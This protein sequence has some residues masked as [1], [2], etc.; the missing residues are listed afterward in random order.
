MKLF[1]AREIGGEKGYFIF[2]ADFFVLFGFLIL[3]IE[4]GN[5]LNVIRKYLGGGI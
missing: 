4:F 5:F 3:C 1:L 2:I